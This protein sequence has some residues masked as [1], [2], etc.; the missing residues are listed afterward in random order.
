MS[1]SPAAPLFR[2]NGPLPGAVRV[3]ALGPPN[4]PRAVFVHGSTSWGDDPVYGFAAQRPLAGRFRLLLMDRRGHGGSPDA[5][6]RFAG[7]YLAD[8]DDVAEL[9]GAGAHLVGHSYGAVGAMIAAA[10]RPEAVLSLT[11]IEPG[12]YQA[13]ADDPAVAEALRA[14]RAAYADLPDLTPEQWLRAAA[15]S[16]G[17]PEPDTGERRLRAAGTALRE[18]VCWEAGVPLPAL[19]AAGFPKLVVSGTWENAPGPYRERGGVPLM[20]CAR[21]TA[22]RIGARH[23]RVPGSAHYPHVEA[24]EQVNGALAD[25]WSRG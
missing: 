20:A 5:G 23:L 8:A 13:A 21:V 15:G 11:L 9:L 2:A 1:L 14:N 10:R 22:E 25:L 17:M 19:R 6:D 18:R 24:P 16:A 4:A 3:T 7:D 12:C